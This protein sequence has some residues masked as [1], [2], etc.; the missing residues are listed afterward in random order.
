[1]LNSSLLGGSKPSS[2]GLCPPKIPHDDNEV[3]CGCKL[4]AEMREV[5]GCHC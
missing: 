5:D 1:M 3:V 4:M 2:G